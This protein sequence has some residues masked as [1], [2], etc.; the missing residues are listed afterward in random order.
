MS[1][2]SIMRRSVDPL[3]VLE[4]VVK[5]TVWGGPEAVGFTTAEGPLWHQTGDHIWAVTHCARGVLELPGLLGS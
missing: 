3:K 5:L 4:R 2:S 1:F